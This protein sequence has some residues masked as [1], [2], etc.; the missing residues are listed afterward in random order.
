[1]MI[2][3]TCNLCALHCAFANVILRSG[4]YSLWNV[5][6]LPVCSPELS[7]ARTLSHQQVAVHCHRVPQVCQLDVSG[8]DKQLALRARKMT[9]VLKEKDS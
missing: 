5:L 7:L 6:T 3:F 9:E 8:A 2:S 4:L 1:M